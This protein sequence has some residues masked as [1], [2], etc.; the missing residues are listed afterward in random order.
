MSTYVFPARTSSA[1][2]ELGSTLQPKFGPD[3]LIPCITQDVQS[4]EVLMFAFMNA[5]SLAHTTRD[6]EGDLLEPLA[7]EALGQGRGVRQ[8]AARA[9]AA[10][11]LRPGRAADQGRTGGPGERELPQRLQVPASTAKLSD[12]R[13][14]RG[15]GLQNSPSP[16]SRCSIRRTVY[17]KK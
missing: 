10:H 9:R 17:K 3:G 2:I 12:P 6:G 11:R 8:C 7:P 5:E 4:G 13:R 15:D 16:P 1:E 14:R